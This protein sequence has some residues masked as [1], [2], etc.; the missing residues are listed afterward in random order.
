[1]LPAL[2]TAEGAQRRAGKSLNIFCA[3][4][5]PGFCPQIHGTNLGTPCFADRL[6]LFLGIFRLAHPH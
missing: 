5:V 1:M 6:S 4:A 2:P 3:L